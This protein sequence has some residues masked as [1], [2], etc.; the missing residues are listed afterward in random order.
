MR[1]S[2]AKAKYLK[3]QHC[4]V[5]VKGEIFTSPTL[6]CTG[7]KAKFLQ[8]P[9]VRSSGTKAKFLQVPHVFGSGTKTKFLQVLHVRGSCMKSK[10]LQLPSWVLVVRSRNFT[11]PPRAC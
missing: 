5:L 7:R 6:R 8:V 4:V 11:S 2:G 10:F 1:G 9:H 3:V